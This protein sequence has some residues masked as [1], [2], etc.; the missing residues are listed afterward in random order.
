[1]TARALIVMDLSMPDMHG[2][3][4]IHRIRSTA[5]TASISI[6]VVSGYALDATQGGARD[7]RAA[8]FPHK[9]VLAR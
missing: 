9:A 3:K 8:A 6:V 5:R 4:A 1:V 2:W 7:A